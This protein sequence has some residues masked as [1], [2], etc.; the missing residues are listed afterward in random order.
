M[1]FIQNILTSI[2]FQKLVNQKKISAFFGWLSN[3]HIPPRLLRRV[4][5]KFI[6][7]HQIDISQY[8][9]DITKVKSFNEF[10]IRKLKSGQRVFDGK[11]CS[12][13]D[14]FI[15]SF[16]PISHNQ[17]F[18]VKGNYYPLEMLLNQEE[19]FHNGSFITTYLSP[20]DYHRVHVPFD[21]TITKVKKIPGKL[22]SVNKK[23][24]ETIDKVYCRNERIVLE[25]I[26]SFG[27]FYLVLVGAI[28]VG[29]IKLSFT[30]QILKFNETYSYNIS[31]KQGDEVGYFEL[32]ST[33]L[34]ILE[35]NDLANLKFSPHQKI[36]LGDKLC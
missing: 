1:N 34:L 16:G 15:S 10:F 14:G 25:G 19:S 17:L 36:H 28:V 32:G 6:K 26:A 2:T 8:D 18:Q 11:I 22:Y 21:A 5:R 13:V 27:K 29:K 30:N 20:A 31:L 12:S 9:F 35:S 24:I 3:A 7:T 4:I 23:T 33:V